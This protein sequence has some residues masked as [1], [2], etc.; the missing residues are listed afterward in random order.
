MRY[1]AEHKAEV[2]EKIV[3]DAAQRV[4]REGLTGAA[5]TEVM[6]DAGLTHGGF[7]KHFEN[8]EALL[9]EALRE[10]FGEFEDELVHAAQQAKPGTGW[11]AIVKIYLSPE[12]CDHAESG[13]P[14]AALAPEL[15]RVDAAMRGPIAG[16]LV[17]YRDR[18]LPFMPGRRKDDK[19]RAFFAIWSTMI[20]AIALARILPF[21]EA[22]A[23]VLGSARDLLLRSY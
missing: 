8:K 7:Y 21:P 11:K 20:G 19:E 14:V 4:R 9:L 10:G 15:A 5:V 16:E 12:H 13:C 17:R 6:R 2:H 23:K 18:M 3:R 22:R 1:S